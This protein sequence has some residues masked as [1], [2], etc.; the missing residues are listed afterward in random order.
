MRLRHGLRQCGNGFART[1]VRWLRPQNRAVA[2]RLQQKTRWISCLGDAHPNPGRVGCPPGRLLVEL[3]RRQRSICDL[4]YEHLGECS[5]CYREVRALQQAESGA[6]GP[7]IRQPSCGRHGRHALCLHALHN[8]Q[9][10]IQ[11]IVASFTK[12]LR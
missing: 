5:S 2:V 11:L 1:G 10:C 4:W 3:A 8:V 12:S 9:C 7:L 6:D